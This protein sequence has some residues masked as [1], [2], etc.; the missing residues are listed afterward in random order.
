[1]DT[2]TTTNE[3][4]INITVSS[5]KKIRNLIA[6][7]TGVLVVLPALINAGMDIRNAL[8]NIPQT[9]A[10][11]TNNKLFKKY[12]GQPPLLINTVPIISEFGTIDME[13]Q[14]FSKGDILVKYGDYSHWFQFPLTKTTVSNSIISS[15]FASDAEKFDQPDTY[16]Q[17][18]IMKEGKIQREYY[19]PGRNY[20]RVCEIDTVSGR[21]NCS[22]EHGSFTE[23]MPNDVSEPVKVHQ[24]AAIDLTK[25]VNCWRLEPNSSRVICKKAFMTCSPGWT[26]GN[27][28]ANNN[29]VE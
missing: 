1:M 16:Q 22:Y 26:E 8:L 2:V 23:S 19:Y 17:R 7:L 13:L 3:P 25:F 12:F 27:P 11:I 15:A 20:K 5:F 14:V 6:G 4:R 21:W 9:E 24:G 28:P 29:C 18:D 10:G